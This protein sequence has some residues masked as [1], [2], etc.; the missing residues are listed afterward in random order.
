MLPLTVTDAANDSE[1]QTFDPR[2]SRAIAALMPD[3]YQDRDRLAG[4][5]A[6]EWG[7][8]ESTPTEAPPVE[9]DEALP[10]SPQ[11][12]KVVE[13]AEANLY[14]L[15][16]GEEL[17]EKRAE[18]ERTGQL[19]ERL[20]RR[21]SIEDVRDLL[22][23]GANPGVADEHGQTALMHAAWPPLDRERFRLLVRAGADVE[24]RRHDGLT[25][26][27]LACSGGEA[28]AAEEW[29]RAGADVHARTPEGATPL[30]LGAKWPRVVR[31]LLDA[32]ADVNAA[33]QDG[34]TPLVYAISEQC[35]VSAEGQLEAVRE[36]LAAGADVNRR[37]LA[38]TTPLGHARRMLARAQLEEEVCRAF[39][40]DS[41]PLGMEWD[42]RRL[43]EAICELVSATG[44]RA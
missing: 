25:G 6:L 36:L 35:W 7:A 9:P 29:V 37:D 38:G 41:G 26:L 8:E 5:V 17:P 15:L 11:Q 20:L 24:A 30:M 12:L 13:Q 40:P 28:E 23:R 27:L 44:E 16:L 31:V 39:N 18:A 19:S 4:L 21:N 42:D 14:R 1:D 32:G 43:A 22:H 3:G 10:A 33:D 2:L 34:H